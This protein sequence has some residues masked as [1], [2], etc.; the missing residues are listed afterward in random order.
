[1]EIKNL[2]SAARRAVLGL[3]V[4]L[5]IAF[6]S[7]PALA[8][9]PIA[10]IDS[11]RVSQR[12]DGALELLKDETG[13]LSFED[14]QT[15]EIAARFE[16]NP[17]PAV[18]HG[19]TK[20]AYWYRLRLRND[21]ADSDPAHVLEIDYPPLDAIDIYLTQNGTTRVIRTGDQRPT[22]AILLSHHNYA[23]P[24]SLAPGSELT[25][26]LRVQTE[27]SHQVPLLI[28]S[29]KSFLAKTE[30]E[31][32][33]FG[34]FF[35]VMLIMALYNVFILLFVRD[36][37]YIYYIGTLLFFSLMQLNL[38]GFMRQYGQDLLGGALYLNNLAVPV[39]V[40]TTLMWALAFTRSFLETRV[41]TPRIHLAINVILVILVACLGLAFVAPYSTSVPAAAALGAIT[42]PMVIVAGVASLRAG[43]RVARFFLLAWI[44]FLLGI[45]VKVSELFGALPTS[46]IT[47]YA[48]QIG[49]LVTVTVLSL[50]LADRINIER[51]ERLDAQGEALAAREQAI[52]SLKRYGRIVENVLE[53]IFETDFEGRVVSANAAA[54]RMFGYASPEE[55]MTTI[56]SLREEHIAVQAVGGEEMFGL[57]RNHGQF[58]GLELELRRRDGARFWASVSMRVIREGGKVAGFDGIVND[59]SE[60]HEKEKLSRERAV[61]QAAT[62]AKSEFLAKMSH[63]LRTPMNAI[64]GFTD[65]ALRSE[66]E[67][68]RTAHLR[69]I[70]TASHTLLQIVNDILDLSKIE[71]GKL[72]LDLRSFELQ[73]ILDRVAELVSP[74]ATA[75]GVEIIVQ[76]DRTAPAVLIGDP[77]RL[78]QV[79]MN[80]MG[81]AVKFTER[82]EVELRV[83]CL[84]NEGDRLQLRF[85]VKDSGIGLTAEQRARLFTPFTQADQST[86][87]KYGGT[88]LGLAICKQ[89]VELMG[90]EIAVES[91]PGKG[92][93]FYF[94]AEFRPGEALAPSPSADNLRGTR[95]LVVD[96][97]AAARR[98]YGEILQSLQ[99]TAA[100]AESGAQAL[101]ALQKNTYDLLL[102]D[103]KMPEMDGLEAVRRVRAQPQWQNLPVILMTAHGQQGLAESAESAGANRCLEKPIKPSLLLETIMEL[104][105]PG[106]AVEI[107]VREPIHGSAEAQK[108]RGTQILLAEDN[109]M[110][111]KLATEILSEAGVSLDYA[112]NGQFAIE[113]VQRKAYDA[114][115]MDVQMPVMDGYEATRRIRA[116]PQFARLPI[117]AMTANAMTQ[118]R[119]DCLAAGMNDFLSKPIDA[120][121]MLALLSR[122]INAPGM[123]E[124]PAS[125]TPVK[126]TAAVPE[127]LPG[128]EL[129]AAA[130]R[131]GGRSSLLIELLLEFVRDQADAPQRLRAQL[132]NN[133]RTEAQR[134]AHTIKG[135]AGNV[136]CNRLAAAMQAL[137]QA[138]QNQPDKVDSLMAEFESAL[139]E[140]RNSAATLAVPV[141]TA[142]VPRSEKPLNGE[143]SALGDLLRKQDFQARVHLDRLLGDLRAQ[144]GESEATALKTAV[145]AYD[146]AAATLVLERIQQGLEPKA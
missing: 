98:M 70:E 48:W 120:R 88:G 75:K 40:S 3:L 83:A 94:T 54:A 137:E 141:A 96:D 97:N 30:R 46:F 2:A 21:A 126:T 29:A 38:T 39:L 63:E 32:L 51:Q 118:D 92:S 12:L 143:L 134:S 23:I 144:C 5:C 146:F 119:E 109:A 103:W 130:K 47:A 56:K 136:G 50:A 135:L 1:M 34:V 113:A 41:H 128:I 139:Q 108:L 71:A 13:Q 7:S 60:R 15:P 74:S 123:P 85:E 101:S 100:T 58:S 10:G 132:A 90:G 87:R 77:L 62:A 64:V 72:A 55:M 111:R 8:E 35:G 43:V 45:L 44:T 9:I 17:K 114:V 82:G 67:Q 52:A 28:W 36:R 31:N 89:L 42:S 78:E 104:R 49:I 66:S 27:G 140:V 116:Q 61:A 73:P 117:I 112:E 121:E 76:S 145:Y 86:T 107:A 16:A 59:I 19:F 18:N 80:L 93:S 53:G 69:H 25:L 115:L 102:V 122:W 22:S 4:V 26:Y 110:N 95:V 57:L 14:V 142:A 127:R 65:L 84:G 79:L 91:V 125:P 24:L 6:A 133:Q 106:R 99:M 129:A 124:P 105:H 20:H 37:A 68:R 33:A 138:I 131:I 81:N 11:A